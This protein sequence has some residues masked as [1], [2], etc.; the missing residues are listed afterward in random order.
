[1]ENSAPTRIKGWEKVKEEEF[2]KESS[3]I[4]K[5]KKKDMHFLSPPE[6]IIKISVRL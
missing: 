3:M 4:K 1:M 5:K 2:L 6:Q